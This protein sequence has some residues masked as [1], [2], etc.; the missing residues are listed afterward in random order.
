MGWRITLTCLRRSRKNRAIR[1]VAELLPTPVRTAE[2][3]ITGLVEAMVVL[4]DPKK[5]KLAP[6]AN[7]ADALCITSWWEM[8][9]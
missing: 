6:A 5:A 9:L 2:T 8:S 4:S 1:R 3:L 7:T